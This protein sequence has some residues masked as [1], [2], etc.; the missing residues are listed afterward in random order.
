MGLI[1]IMDK[2]VL[3]AATVPSMIGCFNMDN[4]RILLQMGYKV[5]V[6]CDFTDTSVWPIDRIEQFKKELDGAGIECIQLNFSRNPLK[7]NRHLSSYTKVMSLLNKRRYTFIHTHTP[8]ASAIIR[9]AAHKTGTK[10]IYTAHG[11]HFFDGAPIKNWV[12]FYPIEKWLSKY[13][14]VLITINEE[15]YKRANSR[16]KAKKTVYIPGVGVDTQKFEQFG[17]DRS[18]TRKELNIPQDATLLI[19]VGELSINKNHKIVVK[20]LNKIKDSNLYY[21]IAGKGQLKNDLKQLDTTGRLRLLG[22][23]TD[24]ADLLH[25]ADLFVFPSLREGL[26]VALMEA[27]AAGVRCAC[28][29]IRGNTDLVDENNGYLFDANSVESVSTAIKDALRH[30]DVSK[31]ELMKKKI[32]GFDKSFINE[33]MKKVY[34]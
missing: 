30:N 20:A 7:I 32:K 34:L 9:L 6:I 17:K 21:I 16:F 1:K 12:A 26:P 15:D 31:I 24:I 29:R 23:R 10:V 19:S 22:Y 5:D 4:I 33:E 8:I 28:S 27:M 25:A 13:T 18:E 14:D 3:M 11:F 2:R